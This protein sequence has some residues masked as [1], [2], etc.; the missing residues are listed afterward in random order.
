MCIVSITRLMPGVHQPDPPGLIHDDLRL[1][2]PWRGSSLS[3]PFAIRYGRRARQ[4][5]RNAV[6]AAAVIHSC[7]FIHSSRRSDGAMSSAARRL[8]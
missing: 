3:G 4:W 2:P 1:L 7:G 6:F 8:G 5:L